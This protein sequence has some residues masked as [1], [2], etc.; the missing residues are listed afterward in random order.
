MWHTA[1]RTRLRSNGIFFLKNLLL[2]W[3]PLANFFCNEPDMGMPAVFGGPFDVGASC[4]DVNFLN[5]LNILVVIA[6]RYIFYIQMN[7]YVSSFVHRQRTSI[8]IYYFMYSVAKWTVI[9]SIHW[10]LQLHL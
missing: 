9:R 1:H 7:P 5:A 8:I 6:F 10:R 3:T 4:F 2:Y